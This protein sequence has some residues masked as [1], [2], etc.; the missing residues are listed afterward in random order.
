[1]ISIIVFSKGRP[2]QLHAYLESLLR[3]SDAQQSMITVLYC[4]TEG[5]RYDKVMKK[6][7]EISWIKESKFETNLKQTISQADDY[8]MFG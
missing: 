1:M 5:I 4:E 6:F 8:I 7:P 2:M 3:F